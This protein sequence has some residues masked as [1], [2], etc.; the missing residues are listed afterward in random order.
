MES[1]NCCRNC[2]CCAEELWVTAVYSQMLAFGFV[3]MLVSNADCVAVR[4]GA[5][6]LHAALVT[7]F[8]I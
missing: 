8:V 2:S 6:P 1:E 7:V 3:V 4:K 5:D